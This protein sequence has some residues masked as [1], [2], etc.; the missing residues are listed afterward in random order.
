VEKVYRYTPS[1][2]TIIHHSKN[3]NLLSWIQVE[4]ALRCLHDHSDADTLDG[5]TWALYNADV[6]ILIL[7]FTLKVNIREITYLIQLIAMM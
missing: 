1:R 2:Y 3:Q 4:Q 6:V 5:A 7:Y